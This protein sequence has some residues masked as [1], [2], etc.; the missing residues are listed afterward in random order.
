MAAACSLA[1]ATAQECKIPTATPSSDNILTPAQAVQFGNII[2]EQVGPELEI[3]NNDRVTAELQRIG[4]RLTKPLSPDMPVRFFLS[5][6]PVANAFTFPGGRVYVTRKLVALTHSEDELAAVM[7]HELGHVMAHDPEVSLSYKLQKVLGISHL[8]ADADLLHVYNQLIDNFARN[9]SKAKHEREERVQVSADRIGVFALAS[10]GYDPRA[11]AQFWDRMTEN[12]SAKG[13]WFSDL[14]GS[15]TPDSLRFREAL[16]D[17]AALPA[18]CV[19]KAPGDAKQYEALK[20]AVIKNE[21]VADN[22][23]V[24][25]VSR[26]VKL[27]PPL[28]PDLSRIRFSADGKW[29]LAQDETSVYIVSRNPLAFRFRI[30]APDAWKAQFSPDSREVVFHDQKLRVERW[31]L[32]EQKQTFVQE[33]AVPDG[34]FQSELAPDGKTLACIDVEMTLRLVDV[35]SGETWFEK[36][37]FYSFDYEDLWSLA[38]IIDKAALEEEDPKFRMFQMV[39]TPDAHYLIVARGDT[40]IAID[41][42]QHKPIPLNG[43]VSHVLAGGFTFYGPDRILGINVQDNRKSGMVRFPS[44]ESL[45]TYAISPRELEAPA[46]GDQYAVV[47]PSGQYASGLL[48]LAKQQVVLGNKT[49]ALD[50]Y[51]DNFAAERKGGELEFYRMPS[52][53]V[54]GRV[55]LPDAPLGPLRAASISLNFD[56]L[57][58]SD[59]SRGG[60]WDTR[61]G[62]LRVLLTGFRGAYLSPDGGLYAMF[63]KQRGSANP[64]ALVRLGLEQ[65]GVTPMFELDTE[66]VNATNIDSG[67]IADGE[68]PRSLPPSMVKVKGS[69]L[70]EFGH[71]VMARAW[72]KEKG[73]S[74]SIDLTIYDTTSGKQLWTRRF[75]KQVP[76]HIA[77]DNQVLIF[78]LD[79]SDKTSQNVIASESALRA[80]FLSLQEKK[81]VA[82]LDIVAADSGKQ[83]GRLFVDTGR[84]SFKLKD[85]ETS[86]DYV[87]IADDHNRSLVYR[88]SSGTQLGSVF[89]K[90]S[91]LSAA[92]NLLM[93]EN[94]NGEATLYSLPSVSKVDDLRFGSRLRFARFSPDGKRL[95]VLTE[96][97]EAYLLDVSGEGTGARD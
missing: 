81:G 83:L 73:S 54:V 50:I 57:A 84:D 8:G 19:H 30:D 46:H 92:S 41:V 49:A 40:H 27:D 22:Q 10:A 63:P 15:T 3:V 93:V 35:A 77:D 67:D 13:N 11:F 94:N 53:E 20:A 62:K 45:A 89:G 26:K 36:K 2:A 65:A 85:V 38:S 72:V 42:P 4:D 43:A 23:R 60:V 90:R 87:V 59:A 95:F 61:D 82:M 56:S 33:I 69:S 74:N 28:R 58:I 21:A 47:R 64:T 9:P 52:R 70:L 68:Q 25:H 18:A 34:C 78:K 71:V 37:R 6:L 24:G 66:R 51:D 14:F 16:K 17:T 1:I 39:F 86:G 76:I 44:G 96:K 7:A 32:A 29:V 88:I 91:T 97:Q 80:Q 5:D 55:T 12:K 75:A 79:A 48:D 31:D